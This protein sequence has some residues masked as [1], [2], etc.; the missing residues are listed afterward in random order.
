MSSISVRPRFPGLWTCGLLSLITQ[1]V[2]FALKGRLRER[3]E[4]LHRR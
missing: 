2:G 4:D 1:N 3:V